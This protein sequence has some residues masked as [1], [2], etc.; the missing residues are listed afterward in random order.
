MILALY[1]D[2]STEWSELVYRSEKGREK[3]LCVGEGKK[4]RRTQRRNEG[5]GRLWPVLSAFSSPISSHTCSNVLLS[6]ALFFLPPSVLLWLLVGVA[7]CVRGKPENFL[8]SVIMSFHGGRLVTCIFRVRRR[9]S[10][11]KWSLPRFG[12]SCHESGVWAASIIKPLNKKLQPDNT[13]GKYV[14]RCERGRMA[15]KAT[16]EGAH[17]HKHTHRHGY[18]EPL[19]QVNAWPAGV[20]FIELLVSAALLKPLGQRPHLRPI[21]RRTNESFFVSVVTRATSCNHRPRHND[22]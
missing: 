3:D 12:H 20:W 22:T 9:K 16:S 10:Q 15:E 8:R 11:N 2:F 5:L 6:G 21:A 4:K 14:C 13:D 19:V 17:A 7:L 18:H 1:A